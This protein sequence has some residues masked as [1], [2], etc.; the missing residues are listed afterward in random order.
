MGL[1]DKLMETFS[2]A[3]EWKGKRFEKFVIDGF[4][5]KYFDIVE[6]THS[7]KTN[8]ERFVESSINPDYVLRYRPT[9][10]V[11]AVECKYRSRL[12]PQGMLEYCKPH[13]FEHYKKFMETRKIP[14]FIVVGVG[15]VDEDP[16]D[17]FILPLKEMKYPSLYPSI[18]KQYSRNPQNDFFWKN[19]KLS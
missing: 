2:N 4:D 15:G 12:N 18:Y 1:F 5:E 8:Q 6:Q 17:L 9:K 14:V 13:Q 19:G 11:F 7:W 3:P 10:E 16:D